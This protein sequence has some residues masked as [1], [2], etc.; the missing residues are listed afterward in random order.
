MRGKTTMRK[1]SYRLLSLH[2]GLTYLFLYGPIVLLIVLSFNGSGLATSWG[3]F[4]L[5]WYHVLF[6]DKDIV[7]PTINTLIVA[8]S[9]S[10]IAVVLG[11]LLAMG[12]ERMK[13][14]AKLDA[15]LFAPMVVPDIVLAIALLSFFTALRMTLGLHS[16]VLAHVVFSIAFVCAVVRTR[17]NNFDASLIEA[18]ID[19]GA[20][21]WQTFWRVTLP[22]IS[23][24][25][26]AGGLLSFTLSF[27][28][29]VI[30]FFTAGP[31]GASKTLSMH[32]YSMIRFGITPEI[33]A[34]A[35]LIIGGSF[36]LVLVAQRFNREALT[37]K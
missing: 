20:T 16:I 36:L 19:L 25:V 2:L 28:E 4:S 35:T 3:G 5:K 18:S 26:I 24:G 34:L 32:I 30:A 31:T 22:I 33:N 8:A 29:F 37:D 27:D 17:L 14:S 23:P 12:V 11:T 13:P 10:S 6:S 1:G 7:R 9:A 21:R 15:V